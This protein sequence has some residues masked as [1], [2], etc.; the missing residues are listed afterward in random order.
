VRRLI[1]VAAVLLAVAGGVTG[2]ASTGPV[3]T[4]LGTWVGA[5]EAAF[6][7]VLDRSHIRYDYEGSRAPG[8]LLQ[9]RIEKGAPP[10]IVLLP[11]FGELAPYIQSGQ[12]RP[13]GKLLGAELDNY[14]QPWVQQVNG[15]HGPDNYWVPI[16]A[17]LKS[18]VWY[19]PDHPPL[20][21]TPAGWTWAQLSRLR[22][23]VGVGDTPNSGWPASDW[24]EDLLLHQAGPVAYAEWASGQLGPTG[25]ALQW[26]S[27]EMR[28]AW[29][30]WGQLMAG[31][32]GGGSA[33]LLTDQ[34]DA[35]RGM[36][37]AAGPTGGCQL[38]HQ[39]SFAINP[40]AGVAGRRDFVPMPLAPKP[41]A[42][43]VSAD[44]ASLFTDSPQA[45]NMIRY[46]AGNEAQ[47]VWPANATDPAFSVDRS[48]ALPAQADSG[49]RS[50]V[51]AVL[52][53]HDQVCLD[54]GD[55]MPATLRDAFYRGLLE[56]MAAVASAAKDE[57]GAMQGQLP[58]I[59]A[60][61]LA[62]L[63]ELRT[64]LPGAASSLGLTACGS[65]G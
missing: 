38:E 54:A 41:R 48:A 65:A 21:G 14:A 24:I 5:E 35:A 47:A 26:S 55:L 7:Q 49:V 16:K 6:R 44:V 61:I 51:A 12:V 56:Y 63:D 60:T 33:A 62:G 8:A 23:C 30:T 39:A 18:I 59:L 31:L 15:R 32:P 37:G 1:G 43:E 11:T 10:D 13:L 64:R 4:I 25:S 9:S 57:S 28:G 17:D 42:W 27:P 52:R 20:G 2:C 40:P 19:D 46:L 50:R 29:T 3:V 36:Y 45:E 34:G 53:G 58:R 22:W